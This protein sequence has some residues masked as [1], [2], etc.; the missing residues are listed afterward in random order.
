MHY[1]SLNGSS[2]FYRIPFLQP[3]GAALLLLILQLW[4]PQTASAQLGPGDPDI[5][6]M[7]SSH[8][9]TDSLCPGDIITYGIKVHAPF[10][11][12]SNAGAVCAFR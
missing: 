3:L 1:F 10:S 11:N 12:V 8:T 9:G 7:T 5:V 2:N 6:E 4:L